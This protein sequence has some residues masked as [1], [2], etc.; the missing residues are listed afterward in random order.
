MMSVCSELSHVVNCDF[1][2]TQLSVLEV[3]NCHLFSFA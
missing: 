2:S 1:F 3:I